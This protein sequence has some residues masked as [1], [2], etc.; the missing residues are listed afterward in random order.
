MPA[1]AKFPPLASRRDNDW[2]N[3]CPT[4]CLATLN[5]ILASHLII[6]AFSCQPAMPASQPDCL[7]ACLPV[8]LPNA[9]SGENV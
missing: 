7:F 4:F 1:A 5:Y 3:I 6:P 8:C 9:L 2:I